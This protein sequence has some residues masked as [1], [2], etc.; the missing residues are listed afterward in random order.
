M[1]WGTH[2][3][4]EGWRGV[5][6]IKAALGHSGRHIDDDHYGV[7]VPFHIGPLSDP[8]VVNF[9]AAMGARRGTEVQM[10]MIAAGDQA[11]VVDAFR[12]FVDVGV[13][14]FSRFRLAA[15]FRTLRH[16]CDDWQKRSP[17]KFKA[18]EVKVSPLLATTEVGGTSLP[19]TFFFSRERQV[20]G[21]LTALRLLK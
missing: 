7:V 14:K 9:C 20:L 15:T 21:L 16:R 18:D 6:R 17:P 5:A 4:G 19:P 12:H 1:A 8:A 3:A 11:A 10:P 2:D 13:S